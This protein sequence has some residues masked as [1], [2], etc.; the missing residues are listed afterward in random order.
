MPFAGIVPSLSGSRPALD[1]MIGRRVERSALGEQARTRDMVELK[2][3]SLRVTE[4][5]R[6]VARRPRPL[7]RRPDDVG[8]D[9]LHELV[10]AVDVLTAPRAKAQMIEPGPGLDM[11]DIGMLG[12]GFPDRH[13]RAP[14]NVVDEEVRARR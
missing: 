12:I 4:G 11:G 3:D 10:D 9:L 2:P 7:L 14:A 5:E 8:A 1:R 13:R 6:V